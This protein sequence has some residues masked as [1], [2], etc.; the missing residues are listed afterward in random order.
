MSLSPLQSH[1]YQQLEAR[2][3]HVLLAVRLEQLKYIGGN[4]HLVTHEGKSY[5]KNF[6]FF[7]EVR[8]LALVNSFMF[9]YHDFELAVHR[10]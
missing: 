1:S 5:Q 9:S 2:T 7:L 4:L 10:P 6:E 3:S 8:H